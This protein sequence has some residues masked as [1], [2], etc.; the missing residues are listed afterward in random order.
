[1]DYGGNAVEEARTFRP[2]N[3]NSL[4][5][6]SMHS[7]LMVK[8]ESMSGIQYRLPHSHTPTYNEWAFVC[9]FGSNA[10]NVCALY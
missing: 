5:E 3:A 6:D 4:V 1:M 7:W 8:I 2:M 9:V 10:S